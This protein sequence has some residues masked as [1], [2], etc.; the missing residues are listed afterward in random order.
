MVSI[1]S[2]NDYIFFTKCI[3][4]FANDY[5]FLCYVLK[6]CLSVL[7]LIIAHWV[8]FT[9]HQCL[10]ELIHYGSVA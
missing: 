1:Q 7:E 4:L 10:T 9:V 8:Y 5:Q 3:S 6:Q 2:S